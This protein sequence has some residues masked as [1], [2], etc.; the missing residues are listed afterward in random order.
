[1]RLWCAKVELKVGPRHK[2]HRVVDDAHV[3]I[4]AIETA[5]G[6]VDEGA[7]LLALI[8]AHEDITEQAVEMVIADSRYGSVGNLIE[9]Q[10]SGFVLI[11]R[12][13]GEST[14]GKG[15]RA[16]IYGEER[17]IYDPLSNSRK[18]KRQEN[19][20]ASNRPYPYIDRL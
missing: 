10:K 4:P 16:G 11:S 12:L 9:C 7:H 14:R 18:H 17:F 13:L 15:R 2:S 6:A 8:E 1:M 20:S 3:T 19:R 5:R